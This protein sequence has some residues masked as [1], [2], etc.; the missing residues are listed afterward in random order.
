MN[1]ALNLLFACYTLLAAA[2]ALAQG[3]FEELSF[4]AEDGVARPYIVYTPSSIRE[5][6][7]RPLLV[8]LH[9]AISSPNIRANP[10]A[11]AQRS[12]FLKLADA[13]RYYVLFPYGQKNA[14][15]FDPVGVNMVLGEVDETLRRFPA[16]PDR[17][18]LSGF[19]D[20]GSGTF[21]IAATRP[22][23]FAGFLAMNGSLPVAAHLGTDPLYPANLNRKPLYVINTRSD[24]LYPAQMMEPV[25]R[26]LSQLVPLENSTPEGGHDMRYL[27]AEIPKLTSFIDN[28]V[29]KAEPSLSWE[30]AKPSGTGWL[31]IERLR[32]EEAPQQW[33]T[34][35]S[36]NM[37]NT[38]ASFG[39]GFDPAY[40][41]GLRVAHTGKAGSTAERM[42]VR[43]GDI[44]VKMGSTPM[45]NPYAPY[46]YLAGKQAGDEA[47]LTVLRDGRETV[48]RG[49]FNPPY[50]YEVFEKQPVSGAVRA[51]LQAG[52][53]TVAA[54]RVAAVRIDFDRLPPHPETLT[55][56]INGHEQTVRARGEQVFEVP[57]RH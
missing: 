2:A 36:L 41:G 38:R 25:I 47:E 34:P 32:P 51:S 5:G 35:Y 26:L 37:R 53:L 16:D 20:G 7:Q 55:L 28:T 3:K 6:E 57:L 23:R 40:R 33:H 43:P 14:G 46:T 21:Y 15:W 12:S 52:R 29:R 8:H 54:S 27:E 31:F 44:I 49:H 13:G 24:M 56:S 30:A 9:G 1:R 42:G 39:M 50:S 10:L 11:S 17:V 19:S 22:G 4:T 18:I 45:D 48:L